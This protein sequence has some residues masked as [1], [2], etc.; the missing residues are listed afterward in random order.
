MRRLLQDP[1]KIVRPYVR[2]GMVVLDIGCGM[3]FFSLPLARIV[4]EA[5]KVVC[6]DL[7][8]KMIGG[9]VRRARKAGLLERIDA[10]IC[11]QRSLKVADLAGNIDFAIVFALVHEVPDKKK[12]FSEVYTAMK[13][14]AQLLLAEPRGHVRKPDFEKAVSIAESVGFEVLCQ[15]AIRRSRAVLLRK[16]QAKV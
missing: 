13:R 11:D 9:L 6:V 7:Q 1:D 14:S 2:E 5:G 16:P 4:G 3:G 8:D 10:R 15:L 12:L